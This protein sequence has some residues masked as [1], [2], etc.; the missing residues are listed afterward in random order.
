MLIPF[1]FDTGLKMPFYFSTLALL[2]LSLGCFLSISPVLGGEEEEDGEEDED[3]LVDDRND[4]NGRFYFCCQNQ[5]SQESL[6][7]CPA[8]SFVFVS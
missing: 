2:L 6:A 4:T 8:M 1:K 7:D 3:D 5:S